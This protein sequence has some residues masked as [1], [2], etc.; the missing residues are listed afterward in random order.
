MKRLH[1]DDSIDERTRLM[2]AQPTLKP[3]DY[4]IPYKKLCTR[5]GLTKE[6]VALLN[7][8]PGH[9]RTDVE[10][11][12]AR[13]RTRLSANI[14]TTQLDIA[15]EPA[16]N[17]A[18]RASL[19]KEIDEMTEHHK[20]YYAMVIPYIVKKHALVTKALCLNQGQPLEIAVVKTKET[21]MAAWRRN[22]PGPVLVTDLLLN[23]L[24]LKGWT[25]AVIEWRQAREPNADSYVYLICDFTE[26]Y[27][28]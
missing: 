17:K 26:Q 18:K 19:Q 15:R 2:A 24:H 10:D 25:N 21:S 8:V 22:Y 14:R 13:E 27:D 5:P 1:D 23:E 12:I 11:M 9:I 16:R 28:R 3:N 6:E 20:N 4:Y 7:S